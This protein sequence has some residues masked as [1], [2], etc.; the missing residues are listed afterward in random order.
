[1][2]TILIEKAICSTDYLEQDLVWKNYYVMMGFECLCQKFI[3]KLIFYLIVKGF[4]AKKEKH[5][6]GNKIV[7]ILCSYQWCFIL[8]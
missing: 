1:M 8:K 6:R 2:S 7:A 3:I 5:L 4:P